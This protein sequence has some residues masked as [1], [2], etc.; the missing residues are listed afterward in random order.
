MP[1]L[2]D[3]D[4][5]SEV[6]KKR[7]APAYLLWLRTV[8]R[9]QQFTSAVVVA[10]LYKGAYRSDRA[11]FHVA[12]IERRVLPAVTVLPF[13]VA[14]ARVYG[15]IEA[16]LQKGGEPLADA[17]LQIAATTLHHGLDLVTGNLRHFGRIAGL[18]LCRKFIEART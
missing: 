4:A 1:Y 7:P 8:P 13:D 11:A 16:T 17:D 10:E 12:N 3:T 15:R 9:E 18:T 2:F 5:L 6:L 14:V